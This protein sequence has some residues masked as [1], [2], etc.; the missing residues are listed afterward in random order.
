MLC[1]YLL[2]KLC[3]LN[4][5]CKPWDFIW[6]PIFE[7]IFELIYRGLYSEGFTVGNLQDMHAC[8]DTATYLGN[9][10]ETHFR[11]CHEQNAMH[12]VT[13]THK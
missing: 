11:S 5:K 10:T 12:V 13:S 6:G 9:Q 3:T 7:R 4:P 1:P 8:E 2:S